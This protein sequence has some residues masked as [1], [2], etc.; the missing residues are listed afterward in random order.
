MLYITT[1]VYSYHS[2]PNPCRMTEIASAQKSE[3]GA[4]S[5]GEKGSD[6]WHRLVPGLGHHQC[7]HSKSW[8]TSNKRFEWRI[9]LPA[10]F[11][12]YT[13]NDGTCIIF[14]THGYLLYT[15]CWY[16][17]MAAGIQICRLTWS[18]LEVWFG[19]LIA[20]DPWQNQSRYPDNT[21]C[22]QLEIPWWT[23]GTRPTAHEDPLEILV[24][25]QL[26]WGLAKVLSGFQHHVQM[27][28]GDY[29]SNAWMTHF[30]MPVLLLS[31][32]VH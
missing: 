20:P 5:V 29:I 18:V 4:K 26:L 6:T 14:P 8:T 23:G 32:L 10:M 7:G 2:V 21:R 15:S 16:I 3:I 31:W 19:K 13:V 28:F 17:V 27:D 1:I 24:D 9:S 25:Q 12:V 22:A 11:E 30:T